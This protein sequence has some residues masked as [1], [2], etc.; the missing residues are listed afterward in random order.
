MG[1]RSHVSDS[2]SVGRDDSITSGCCILQ[3]MGLMLM[4]LIE[5]CGRDR[6]RGDPSDVANVQPGRNAPG[7]S[8][9]AEIESEVRD[10]ADHGDQGK[11]AERRPKAPRPLSEDNN[12]DEE[13]RD[14]VQ[15]G[16]SKRK[17]LMS[18]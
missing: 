12:I 14:T 2:P 1:R 8:S 13:A 17:H 3:L 7:P 16:M 5:V 9:T 11:M 10:Q 18:C 6:E 15:S 4:I